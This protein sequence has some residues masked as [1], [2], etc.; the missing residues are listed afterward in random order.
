MNSYRR[1]EP[2]VYE[3]VPNHSAQSPAHAFGH[4]DLLRCVGGGELLYNTGLQAVLPKFLPGVLSAIVGA[5]T[6]ISR[7]HGKKSLRVQ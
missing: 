5:P 7:P 6:Y 1:W 2:A 4:T 3:H